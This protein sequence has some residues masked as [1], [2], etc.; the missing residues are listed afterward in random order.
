M[1]SRFDKM[2]VAQLKEEQKKKGIL[3][4]DIKGKGKNGSIIKSDRVA[5]LNKYKE[6]TPEKPVP[7]IAQKER[8]DFGTKSV[9]KSKGSG[10]GKTGKGL[11][12]TYKTKTAKTKKV[13]TSAKPKK[14]ASP[15]KASPA[16]TK[17][18]TT[19]TKPKKYATKATPGKIFVLTYQ[20]R[21]DYGEN[22]P[23]GVLSASTFEKLEGIVQQYIFA[24]REDEDHIEDEDFYE[25][26]VEYTL[27]QLDNA[28]KKDGSISGIAPE[29][30]CLY[31]GYLFK[32]VRYQP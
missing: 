17:K 19:F 15:V 1:T 31:V 27:N 25:D 29:L 26:A 16:K 32:N 14:T 28:Y 8:T 9:V 6:K 12:S 30:N 3:D 13:A 4:S 11:R 21:D 18:T 10:R 7:S 2:T 24:H 23:T 20:I 22:T 5:A